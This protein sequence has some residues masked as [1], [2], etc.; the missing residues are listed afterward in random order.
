ERS[1]GF[2]AVQPRNGTITIPAEAR[3]ALR[4][5]LPGAQVEVILRDH[6]LVLRPHVAVPLERVRADGT[7]PG[8]GGG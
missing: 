3:R 1:L 6:D 8:S 7:A 4:L 5:D 2:V